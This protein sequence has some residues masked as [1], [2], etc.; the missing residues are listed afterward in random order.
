M[1][2]R[3]REDWLLQEVL[4]EIDPT[5]WRMLIGCMLLNQTTRKQVDRV[6]PVLF[7]LFPDAVSVTTCDDA[8]DILETMTYPLGLY[9]TRSKRIVKFCDAWVKGSWEF[10]DELPG[11]GE[12]AKDSWRIFKDGDRSFVPYDK[13]LRKYLEVT[14]SQVEPLQ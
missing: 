14:R 6:W 13:E 12:Y 3:S 8:G 2:E 9:A 1:A 11:C 7:E 10:I 4:L 5:G